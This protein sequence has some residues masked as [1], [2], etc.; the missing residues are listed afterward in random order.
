M[1]QR[2]FEKVFWRAKPTSDSPW[3]LALPQLSNGRTG[4]AGARQGPR[5]LVVL[6][7]GPR[8]EAG[9]CPKAAPVQLVARPGQSRVQPACGKVAP[10]VEASHSSARRRGV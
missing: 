8:R 10:S 1:A 5:Y 7:H 6:L 4:K 9:S 2:R 3:S